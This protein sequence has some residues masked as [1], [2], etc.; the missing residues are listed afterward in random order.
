MSSNQTPVVVNATVVAPAPLVATLATSQEISAQVTMIPEI[1]ASIA[2]SFE[3][4]ATVM[5]SQGPAGP[6]GLNGDSSSAVTRI[7]SQNLS[8]HRVIKINAQGLLQYASS[9][10]L[11]DALRVFGITTAAASIGAPCPVVQRGEVVEPSWN[12]NVNLPIYLGSDGVL[13][14]T[15]PSALSAAFSLIV[16]HPISASSM[17]VN[18][19]NPIVLKQ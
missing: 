9:A 7:A 17:F 15:P 4:N 12:W 18:I 16:G 1:N 8:G 14:Q 3:M 13:T 10:L 11:P 2:C 5:A 19:G 6:P